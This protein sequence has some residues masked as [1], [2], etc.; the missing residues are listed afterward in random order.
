VVG[1]LAWAALNLPLYALLVGIFVPFAGSFEDGG[2]QGLLALLAWLLP[3]MPSPGAIGL[4]AVAS[5][6]AG[7]DVPR[8]SVFWAT[9]RARW[10]LSLV[11]SAVSLLI[12]VVLIANLY[13]YAFFGEGWMRFASILWLYGVLFW[14]SLHVYLVPLMVHVA[15]PRLLDLYRRAAL[16]SLGHPAY[17]FVIL[18]GMIAVGTLSLVFL[19]VYVLVGAAY[20]AMVQAHALR[21]IRRRHG[22]L[23]AE[24][25]EEVKPL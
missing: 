12:A 17:T 5:S 6:A 4:A 21:E 16:I 24:T 3:F 25:D 18:V 8:M 14:L 19:P 1:N 23:V 15:E 20:L 22:D 11:A 10:R 7:P 13:F 2:P 9:V